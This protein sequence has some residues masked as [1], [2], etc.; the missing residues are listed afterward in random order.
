MTFVYGVAWFRNNIPYF[1]ELAAPLYDLWNKAMAGK[2][3]RTTQA[4]NKIKLSDLPEWETGAKKAFE[5]VK[6]RLVEALRTSF[7]DPEFRACV[8]ADANDDFWCLCITQCK[9]VEQLLPWAE[10][11]GK[12]KPLLFESGR[13]RKSQLNCI[14]TQLVRRLAVSGESFLTTNTGLSDGCRFDTDLF[15]DHNNLLALFDNEV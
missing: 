11:V 5:D 12:H 6:K 7:Y 15:T 10:Q 4:A 1:T 8:F 14:D 2:K 13:F 3:R 9:D